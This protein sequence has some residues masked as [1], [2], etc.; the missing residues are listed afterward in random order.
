MTSTTP[1]TPTT[2]TPAAVTQQL[3]SSASLDGSASS[4]AS[5][6]F[7]PIKSD[8]SECEMN[9]PP[10]PLSPFLSEKQ[11]WKDDDD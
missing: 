7:E 3:Q 4:S 11:L 6:A 5:A 2:D 9:L 8:P 10:L 1:L